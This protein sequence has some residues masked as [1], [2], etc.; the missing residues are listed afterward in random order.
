MAVYELLYYPDEKLHQTSSPVT[1]FDNNL[2]QLV[3]SMFE[4]MYTDEGIGLAAPQ[5]NI[6]KR[7]VVIDVE[8]DKK[9]E[10]Q[11]VLINPVI[12]EKSGE[13]GIKEGCLSIPGLNAYIP[14]ASEVTVKAQDINGKD[15]TFHAS[16]ILAIC[17]Q[18]ELDHLDGKLFIDYLSPLKKSLYKT[19]A[20]KLAR[21]RKRKMKEERLNN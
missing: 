19:K 2:K 4:T 6:F 5:I 1:N 21:E 15:F 17:I 10:H 7:I 9:P 18:H 8:N 20:E 11:Y 13:N 16:D 14:R 3:T 12:T